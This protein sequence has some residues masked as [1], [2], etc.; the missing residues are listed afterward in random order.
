MNKSKFWDKIAQRYE[1]TNIKDMESYENKLKTTQNYLN[2]EMNVLEIGCGTG[3]T[4]VIHAPFVNHYHATDISSVMI[5][6]AKNKAKEKNIKNMSFEISDILNLSVED[7]S[8]DAVLAMSVLHLIDNTY[9]GIGIIGKKLKTGGLFI[10]STICLGDKM[11]FLKF[12]IPL[13]RLIG[14]APSKV[15]FLKKKELL[16]AIEANNFSIIHEWQ[17]SQTKACFIIAR[18]L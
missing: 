9:E 11:Q 3:T 7:G 2:K 13:M 1:K 6:I 5:E 10:S 16:T 15:H 8:K 12:L 4:A 17:P 18:K 14:Y